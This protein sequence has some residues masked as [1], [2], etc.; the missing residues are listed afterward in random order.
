MA[1]YTP[2]QRSLQ[3]QHDSVALADALD[4]TI[5]VD[6]LDEQAIE[7]IGS[8]DFF[9]LSTVTAEGEPTVS[10]KGGGAGV[11]QVADPTT[12]LFPSYDGNGMYLSMGNIADT[13]F[14]GAELVVRAAIHTA[15]VNCGRYIPKHT[16]VE[17]SPYV[18][19]AQGQA[20]VPAWKRIDVLQPV[21]ATD[22]QAQ[23]QAEG[24]PIDFDEYA[25]RMADGK[26]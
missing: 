25:Q 16:R 15:F 3:E 7:F 14:P 8:R 18:P 23:V 19:N 10:Y 5:I 12:L 9:F 2:A 26:P 11:V 20:P 6:E 1:H 22:V 21:L 24:G 13:H 4:A 17:D